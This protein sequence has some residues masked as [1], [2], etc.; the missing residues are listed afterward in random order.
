MK[1][2]LLAAGRGE[3]LGELT[4]ETPKCLVDIGGEPLLAI[5]LR[6]LA[7]HGVG[8]VRINTHHLASRVEAFLRGHPATGLEVETRFE[9]RL[10][11][12]AGTVRAHRAWLAGGGSFLIAHA[13]NLTSVDLTA[14]RR[15]HDR[16]DGPLTLGLFRT[17]SPTECGIARLDDRGRVVAFEEK[18][19]RPESDLA[20]AGVYLAREELLAWLPDEPAELDFGFD[21]LPA[22]AGR[23]YGWP[24]TDFLADVGTPERLA[25]ARAAWLAQ[26]AFTGSRSPC[27]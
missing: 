8:S 7:R 13:D 25:S 3:R 23:Y 14:M 5:W 10:L 27:R 18:P 15:F 26:E 11:G 12:T 24:I 9:P 21:V 2:I 20:N 19:R 4:R 1:A 16:H 17:P 22:L 6:L